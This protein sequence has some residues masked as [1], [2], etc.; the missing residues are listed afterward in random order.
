M[1]FLG[2]QWQ[3][4]SLYSKLQNLFLDF[5]RGFKPDKICLSGVDHVIS[6]TA[7]DGTIYIRGYTVNY[8]KTVGSSIPTLSLRPMGPFLDLEVRRTQTASEDLWKLACRKP[9][10]LKPPKVKNV[11]K[12]VKGDKIG[13][14]HMKKQNLDELG[15]STRRVPA[16]R[17]TKRGRNTEETERSQ[18]KRQKK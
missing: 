2:D 14:I 12:S 15:G 3:N 8:S 11:E 7:R 17:G 5:F 16:L 6:C 10:N 18:P 4:N 1:V 13:R 9:K